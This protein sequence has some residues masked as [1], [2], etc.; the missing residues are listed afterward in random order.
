MHLDFPGIASSFDDLPVGGFF[1]VKRRTPEFGLC[2]S[3][4]QTK[5]AIIFSYSEKHHAP[6]WLAAGGFP[7]DILISFPQAT[8]RTELSSVSDDDNQSASGAVVSAGGE[9][10]M[11]ARKSLG[12][13]YTFNLRTGTMESPSDDAKALAFSKWQVGLLVDHHFDPI[14]TFPVPAP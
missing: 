5:S 11:R 8:M 6:L 3:D 7:N 10:Y 12:N 14:F 4:G 13:Y 1:M 9:F 2:V